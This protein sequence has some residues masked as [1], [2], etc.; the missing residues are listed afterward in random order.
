YEEVEFLLREE[1]RDYLSYL[2]ILEAIARGNTRLCETNFL[3]IQVK[4]LPKYLNVLI[5][6]DLWKV[7]KLQRKKAT[8]KRSTG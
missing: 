1:L 8:K 2:Y 3:K 7:H 6:L 5:R 4:D